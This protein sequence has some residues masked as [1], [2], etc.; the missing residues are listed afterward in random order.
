MLN[1][2]KEVAAMERMT[3]DQLRARYA[4][5]FGEPTNGRHKEWLIKRIAWRMQANAEGD[6]TERARRRAT[7]LANDSDVRMTPPRE[8]RPTP[9]AED[10]TKTVATK[11]RASA[12]LLPGTV[13]NREYKGQL[14]R[15]TALA[16]GFEYHGERYKSLTAV[17]KA[18]TGKHWN[19]FHFFGLRKK[20]GQR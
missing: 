5:V 3:V 14:I 7:E 16:D 1:V 2:A 8:R 6:L 10:R 20:R 15:V 19:G 12:D 11:L 18:V 17:A 9:D 4:E 13:V